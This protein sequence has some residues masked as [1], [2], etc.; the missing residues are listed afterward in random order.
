[1]SYVREIL[2]TYKNTFLFITSELIKVK[3]KIKA[4]PFWL[5][6]GFPDVLQ[7]L[8]EIDLFYNAYVSLFFFFSIN[9]S[10][11]S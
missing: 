10:R 8:V 5:T 9:I 1:M 3:D 11:N 4:L 2:K 7:L 6:N